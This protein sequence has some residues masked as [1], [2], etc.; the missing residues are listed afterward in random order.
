[1]RARSDVISAT[2]QTL[3]ATTFEALL[4]MQACS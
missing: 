1:M 4:E 3:S 2:M